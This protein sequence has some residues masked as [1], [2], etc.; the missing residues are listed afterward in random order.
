MLVSLITINPRI[1]G[2]NES[3]RMA[4][5]Q[6]LVEQQSFSIDK[7]VFVDGGD[8]VFIEGHFYSDKPPIPSMLG[9]LVYAPLYSAGLTLDF[10]WNLSYYL[11]ILFTVKAFWIASVLE[12]YRALQF[13]GIRKDQKNLVLLLYTLASLS[14][15]W[16]ATF[17]NHSLA[18]SSLMIAFLFYLQAKHQSHKQALFWSG[19]FF[20]L[21]ASMDIPT[22]VFL[23]GFGIL[24]IC[25]DRMR[26]QSL[27][28]LAA[29]LIPLSIHTVINYSIGGTLL[30]LQII[31]EFFIFEG[32]VWDKS[33][34][35]SGV[36]LN[37]AL[38]SLKYAFLCL[39]G[40][41][42]FVWY[43]P[44]LLLL[45]PVM[46][47]IIRR[48]GPFKREALVI[49]LGSF[50]L[51]AYYFVS[52]SNFGGWSYSIR[53][54]VPLLPLIGFFLHAVDLKGQ[55]KWRKY[56]LVVLITIAI[57]IAVIGLVNP[58]SNPDIYPIPLMAN[59]KQLLGILL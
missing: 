35:L 36:R 2:W 1:N 56:I 32:S 40:P 58:W 6:S 31:P 46:I 10:G 17:N 54:F 20:G 8:K 26:I 13:T 53:W 44:L 18:G 43:N 12:F 48:G 28:F 5:T 7:S 55:T 47:R 39:F 27:W 30:P 22:G 16:S 37:S 21:A 14:F 9:A 15:S 57:P 25:R 50:I 29:A 24:I 11:I 41:S 33:T 19:F 34:A 59:L 4:L 38:F 42:G 3:S 49:L 23:L 51:M 52:S 45:I